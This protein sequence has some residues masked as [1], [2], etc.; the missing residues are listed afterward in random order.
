MN[1]TM[2]H[3][4]GTLKNHAISRKLYEQAIEEAVFMPYVRPVDGFGKK[5]GE[6][7]TLIRLPD[8]DEP[9]SGTLVEN[10]KIPEDNM[11]LSSVAIT[12]AEYG[13]AVPYSSLQQDLNEFDIINPIQRRLMTQQKLTLDTAIATA[14]K[15]AKV[16]YIPT[17]VASGVFDTD[18]TPSTTASANVGVFHCEEIADYLYDTLACP[19]WMGEDYMCIARTLAIRGILRDPAWEQWKIYTNPEAKANGEVG[20]LERLR[21]IRTNHANALGTVGT[22]SVLGEMLVFGEDAVAMAEVQTPELRAAQPADFGR[23]LAVAWYG[24]LAFGLIWDTANKGEARVI[25]VTSQ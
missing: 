14:F 17:G 9:T 1:W 21:F 20:R 22:S 15:T 19:P 5:K 10:S 18:G 11:T 12:V 2:D 23:S 7:V 16:T 3:N 24:V 25:R 13:R 8:I 6:T 4:T